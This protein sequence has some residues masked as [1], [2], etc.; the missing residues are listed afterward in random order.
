MEIKVVQTKKDLSDFIFLPWQIYAEDPNWVPPL[1]SEMEALLDPRK[2]PFWEHAQQKLFLVKSLGRVIGRIAGIVDQRHIDFHNEKVGFFGF[3]ESLND[4]EIAELLLS[5]VREWL[6]EKGMKAMRGPMNPSQNEECG[7]LVDAF[8]SS[9]CL[10]MTYN[11]KYY[12][13]LLQKFGLRKVKDLYAYYSPILPEPP[14]L[15]VDAANYARKN[16]P[17]AKIRPVNLKEFEKEKDLIKQIYNA[18]WKKNWG[19]VPMT[20]NEFDALAKRLK[21]LIVPELTLLAEIEGKPA[22]LILAIPDYNQALKKINGHL[23][24][25]GWLKVL[26]YSRKIKMLRLVI[27]G[28]LKE[29]RMQGLEALLYRVGQRNAYRLGYQS[30]E[31][32][33]ILEDNIFTRRAA[34]NY[35]GRIYKTYRVYEMRI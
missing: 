32:S 3:F 19:F 28:V 35:G 4:Y 1:I 11:P 6:R 8:D 24:P 30:V 17:E 13:D 33:W 7:L 14:K 2:N 16:H 5:Q 9:P 20:D 34:E 10:M 22:G 23:F 27:M 29:Y 31:F 25:T 21:P 26:F 18:A 12:M 15:L